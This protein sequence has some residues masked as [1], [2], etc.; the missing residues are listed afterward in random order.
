MEYTPKYLIMINPNANNNKIYHMIP[1]GN[2]FVV[3]YGRVGGGLQSSTYPISQW[4]T[5]YKE[6]LRKGYQDKSELL[7]DLIV[8]NEPD[9]F[10]EIENKNIATI[11]YRLR[12]MA[13]E[14][15]ANNYTISAN[16]V[17]QAMIDSAQSVINELITTKDIAKFNTKLL[18]L[19]SIIPRKMG[20]VSDYLA[21]NNDVIYD[22]LKSEQDL[23]DVMRGQ[24]SQNITTGSTKSPNTQ[25]VTIL[26]SMGLEFQET[27]SSDIRIIKSKLG[28]TA[29]RY[30]N[31]WKITNTKTQLTFDEYIVANNITNTQLFFHGS[32]SQNWWSII[33]SGLLIRPANA[34]YTGSM[35]G[36]AIYT[37]NDADKSLGYTSLSGSRWANGN[38]NTGFL[39]L[40]DTAYGAPY[41]VYDFHSEYYNMNYDKL[42]KY[43]PGATCLHARSD[44][45]MLRKDEIV[46]YK[47]EQLTIKY[48]IELK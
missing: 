14:T 19:F 44:K 41:Y 9:E 21:Q 28:K 23:L 15:I 42:Q 7:D 12:Q 3:K 37:A 40:F 18:E 46:F 45:G 48:L 27:N 36:D 22:I 16:K 38:N 25:D 32:R 5:K 29:Y 33:N 10:K 8:K 35:W 1:Q 11:V 17:T 2:Q 39:A 31:S 13:S 20:K 47:P 34:I 24:V 26:E 4:N 43:Q 6:K 30:C